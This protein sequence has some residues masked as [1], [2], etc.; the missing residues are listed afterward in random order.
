[1]AA[2]VDKTIKKETLYIA[3]WVG[4]LSLLMQAVF[5]IINKWD[6]T[7]LAGNI[8][9]AAIAVSNFFIMGLFVQKAVSADPKEAKK[10][11]KLSYTFRVMFVMVTVAAGVTIPWFSTV[12]V[13]VPLIFPSI[14]VALRAFKKEKSGEVTQPH[15]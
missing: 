4:I 8:W 3:S 9:G 10:I 2:K 6:Y 5:I 15:E 7:V 13:V 12:A 1:M 14:A 11:I